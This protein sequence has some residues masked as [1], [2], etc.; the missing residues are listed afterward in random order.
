MVYDK[1]TQ[2]PQAWFVLVAF[3]YYLDRIRAL[4]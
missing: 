3:V 2:R 4:S 1:Y